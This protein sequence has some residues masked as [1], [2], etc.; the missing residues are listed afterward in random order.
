MRARRLTTVLIAG[1]AVVALGWLMVPAAAQDGPAQDSPG[2][3][4]PGRGEGVPEWTTVYGGFKHLDDVVEL[5][6]GSAW[7]VDRLLVP[8][9]YR[10]SGLVRWQDGIWRVTQV[11]EDTLLTAIS[12]AP[13]ATAFA[14][15]FEGAMVRWNGTYWEPVPA[16][17][18][19]DLRDVSLGRPDDGWACGDY[20]TLLRWDGRAWSRFPLDYPLSTFQYA[21][22]ATLPNG[23]AWA[24]A[25]G[26]QVLRYRGG[27]WEVQETPEIGRPVDIAFDGP[28]HALVVG[29]GALEL[30][31]GTWRSVGLPNT[32]Y[33]SVAWAGGDAYAVANDRLVRYAA[34]T[35]T[36]VTI[37]PGPGN[38]GQV[39]FEAVRPASGGVWAVATTGEIAWLA[40]GVATYAWPPSPRLEALDLAAP[41]VLW[42]AGEAVSAGFIGQVGGN[43]RT[44]AGPAVGSTVWDLDLVS[45]GDGWGVSYASEL[46]STEL[47]RWDGQDV[48]QQSGGQDLAAVAGSDAR[49]R[50]W[51]A[52]WRQHGRPLARR[53]LADTARRAP[54]RL[55]RP[56]DVAWRR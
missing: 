19:R 6:D 29:A 53:W 21:A 30:V 26:G 23:E 40:D 45:G 28:D 1:L 50:R 10:Q 38:L 14:V 25:L 35:W 42:A 56:V 54:G 3:D 52:G 43:W 34:G 46:G 47:W 4:V 36:P 27:A 9:G 8:G 48:V 17:V 11:L 5:P 55:G 31:A 32:S 49:C 15:G 37:A 51:L 18:N 16:I 7:G 12:F 24:T 2:Q 33:R 20:G 22:V 39:D 44:A 13:P 41:D